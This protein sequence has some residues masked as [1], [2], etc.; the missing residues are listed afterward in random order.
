MLQMMSK[1]RA[2]RMKKQDM[3]GG[4]F[5]LASVKDRQHSRGMT[6]SPGFSGNLPGITL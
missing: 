5:T 3:N 2:F 6:F 1:Y 4:F